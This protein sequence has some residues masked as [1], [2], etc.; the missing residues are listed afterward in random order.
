MRIGVIGG[1]DRNQALYQRLANRAGHDLELHTGDMSGRGT[2]ALESLV[3]RIDLLVVVTGLN[4]HGAVQHARR[5]GKEYG[6]A[7]MLVDRLGTARLSLLFEAL[8]KREAP[9]RANAS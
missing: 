4:S 2:D 3:R 6:R 1:L 5:L 9:A 8:A 7:V